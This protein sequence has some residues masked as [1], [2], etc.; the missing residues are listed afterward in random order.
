M[1]RKLKRAGPASNTKMNKFLFR[2]GTL[3]LFLAVVV[4]WRVSINKGEVVVVD[5]KTNPANHIKG[6]LCVCGWVV[7]CAWCLK[8]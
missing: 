1:L 7:L 2:Q 3:A 8:P 6:E 4:M 5:E